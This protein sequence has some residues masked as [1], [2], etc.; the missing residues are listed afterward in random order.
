VKSHDKEKVKRRFEAAKKAKQRHDAEIREAY[1]YS[2]PQIEPEKGP[3]ASTDRTHLY[4]STVISAAGGLVSTI[5]RFLIP[6]DSRWAQL[7]VAEDIRQALSAGAMRTQ[8]DL[9][10]RKLFNELARSNFYVAA[11]KS[12]KDLVVAGTGCIGIEVTADL[13]LNFV[14]VPYDQF[15]FQENGRGVVDVVFRQHRLPARTVVS[16][17]GGDG[18]LPDWVAECAREKPDEPIELIECALPAGRSRFQYCVYTTKNGWK[19]I[20]SAETSFLPFVVFRWEETSDDIWGDSPVRQTLP[21]VKMANEMRRMQLDALDVAAHGAWVT[22]DEALRDQKIVPGGFLFTSDQIG[23]LKFPGDY[24][25]SIEM[26]EQTRTEIRAAL[27]NDA[28]P[29]ADRTG[30]ITAYEISVRQSQFFNRIGPSAILLEDEFLKPII[31]A[32]V[33]ALQAVGKIAEFRID[34]KPVTVT[35]NSVVKRGLAA[36]EIQRNVQLVQLIG[37][38]GDPSMLAIVDKQRLARRIL[39]VGGFTPELIR[40][41]QEVAEELAQ[42]AQMQQLM[43]GADMASKAAPALQSAAAIANASKPREAA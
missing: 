19:L 42:Q 15:F 7:D 34:G 35:T 30:N 26:L 33:Y 21:A 4:D 37:S 1:L 6:Q 18:K 25:V 11:S 27:F 31:T 38:L 20:R 40:D 43:A 9:E 28:L 17:Y 36:E 3:D 2:F 32:C 16:Q 5:L 13:G 39:E 10:T 24:R 8:L 23:E 29:P 22:K 41:E 12:M 14:S